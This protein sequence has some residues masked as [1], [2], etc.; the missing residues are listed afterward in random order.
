MLVRMYAASAVY[1][2]C[3]CM[4]DSSSKHSVSAFHMNVHVHGARCPDVL[5]C[6]SVLFAGRRVGDVTLAPNFQ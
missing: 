5:V 2:K 3:S 4:Y 6:S 1:D